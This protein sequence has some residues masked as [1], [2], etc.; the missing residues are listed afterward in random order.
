MSEQRMEE[1]EMP[2]VPV[3]PSI[4]LARYPELGTR[5]RSILVDTMVLVALM[6]AAGHLFE[7][8]T[9]APEA[10]RMY[11]FLFIWAGYEPLCMTLGG[12]VGNR[13]QGIQVRKAGNEAKRINL[14]QAYVRY[15][16]KLSLGW[17][18]FLTM[19]RDPKRRALHDL[20]SGSVMTVR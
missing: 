12:T 19:G 8:W 1:Q 7:A 11:A 14:L 6:F 10:A 15:A 9:G 13:L 4:D 3:G 17:L 16:V 20:A 5:Y 18:S 2:Q